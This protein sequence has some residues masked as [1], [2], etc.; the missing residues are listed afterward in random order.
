MTT[1]TIS[2]SANIDIAMDMSSLPSGSLFATGRQSTQVD[3]TSNQ[4]VDA[5]VD[6]KGIQCGLTGTSTK[7]GE[8]I[9]LY[10]WGSDTALSSGVPMDAFTGTDG[11]AALAAVSTLNSL[12]FIAAPS[13]TVATTG[14]K[15]YVQPFSIAQQFGGV[16]PKYWGLYAAHNFASGLAPAQTGLFHYAGIK[17][18]ST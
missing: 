11:T 6:V 4:Y 13:V 17:Y 14:L 8:M 10:A 15:Y 9:Q 2:Y 12:Q 18:V 1:E 5:V 3:N 16:M 7:I